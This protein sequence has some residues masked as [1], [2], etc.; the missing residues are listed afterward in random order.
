MNNVVTQ[1]LN[2]YVSHKG[3]SLSQM[4]Y[5]LNISKSH[6][7]EIKN[8]KKVPS[9]DLGLRILNF[10]K[11]TEDQKREWIETSTKLISKNYEHLSQTQADDRKK[12]YLKESLGNIL[13]D[14]LDLLQIFLDVVNTDKVGLN[15]SIVLSEYGES[16]VHDLM[17]LVKLNYL[18]VDNDKFTLGEDVRI[19][20]DKKS[21][22]DLVKTVL[23]QLKKK[24]VL[25]D[26]KGLFQFEIDD[27]SADGVKE[28]EQIHKEAMAKAAEVYK[29]HGKKRSLG[30]ERYIFQMLTARIQNTMKFIILLLFSFLIFKPYHSWAGGAEGGSSNSSMV[31][32]NL[33]SQEEAQSQG[34]LIS[35]KMKKGNIS[36]LEKRSQEICS[37][38]RLGLREGRIVPLKLRVIPQ[39]DLQTGRDNFEAHIEYQIQCRAKR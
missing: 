17:N 14:N 33:S 20:F 34:L 2:T 12:V 27:I 23:S 9:L 13:A 18:T 5:H 7:S 35:E 28:L 19:V 32:P 24:D 31:I 4:A 25:Q 29:K 37:D 3:K 36:E 22:Y 15:R 8:E 6:L 30:G 38:P 11:S 21:S 10:T 16:A 26:H 39:F 1:A